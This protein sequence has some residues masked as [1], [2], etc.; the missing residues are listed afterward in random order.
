MHE[1]NLEYWMKKHEFA[2]TK[3]MLASVIC[4]R[5]FECKLCPLYDSNSDTH[6]KCAER[7]DAWANAECTINEKD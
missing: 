4:T 2:S 6:Q 3:E 5:S 7:F 1:T